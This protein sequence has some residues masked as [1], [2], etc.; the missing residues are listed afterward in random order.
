MYLDNK[1][2]ILT[3]STVVLTVSIIYRT[4]KCVHIRISDTAMYARRPFPPMFPPMFPPDHVFSWMFP[5]DS[6]LQLCTQNFLLFWTHVWTCS[7]PVD[8]WAEVLS[9]L[10]TRTRTSIQYSCVHRIFC[11][12]HGCFVPPLRWSGRSKFRSTRVPRYS[13]TLSRRSVVLVAED[14]IPVFG[15]E[16]DRA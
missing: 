14:G 13:S 5:P 10:S 4:D 2:V 6:T 16:V 15:L 3:V 8:A 1:Y 9:L 11:C 7:V 12:F